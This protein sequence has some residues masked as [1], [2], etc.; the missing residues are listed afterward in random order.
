MLDD[1]AQGDAFAVALRFRGDFFGCLSARRDGLFELADALL[2]ADGPVTAPVDLTLV[3]EPWREHGAKY[4]ALNHW[5]VDVPRLRQ[6][7]AGLPQPQV[8]DGRS[9]SAVR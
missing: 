3:A 7:L 4:D 5:N 8:A 1:N 2:R 6:V 9:R